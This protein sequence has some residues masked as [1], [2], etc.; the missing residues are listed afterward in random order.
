[1][2]EEVKCFDVF[3][4]IERRLLEEVAQD[5]WNKLS[6]NGGRARITKQ[7]D[8]TG[9]VHFGNMI[10]VG[11]YIASVVEQRGGMVDAGEETQG[12]ISKTRV[13][14]H[15]GL[16]VFAVYVWHAEGL[17]PRNESL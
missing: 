7:D 14:C 10:A 13:N 15:G 3:V 12:R 9:K 2:K 5:V 4:D 16:R 17:T 8:A 1:M 6:K 11:N